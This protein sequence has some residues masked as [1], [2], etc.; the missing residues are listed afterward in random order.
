MITV[1]VAVTATPEKV[2]EYWTGEEHIPNWNFAS[3]DWCCPTAKNDLRPGGNLNWRMEA[4]D[5][6]MG[7]DFT[8]TYETIE[9]ERLITYSI[10]DGR[11]VIINFTTEGNQVLIV[12]S[13]EAESM[14]SEDMQR[15]GWQAILDNFKKYVESN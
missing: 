2:W 7:F 6:S 12:E 8:G 10:S 11:K 15:A 3:A 14:H 1:E 9:E 5:G 4:K 13:F